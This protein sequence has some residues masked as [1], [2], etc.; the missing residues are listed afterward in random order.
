MEFWTRNSRKFRGGKYCEI[1]DESSNFACAAG[2]AV[3]VIHTPHP[4]RCGRDAAH[5]RGTM[6][7]KPPEKLD[8]NGRQPFWASA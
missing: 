8:A 2:G 6:A 1:D 5:R 4:P 7:G 3:T